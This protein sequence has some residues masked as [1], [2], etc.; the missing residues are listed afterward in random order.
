MNKE[1]PLEHLA[2]VIVRVWIAGRPAEEVVWIVVFLEVEQD[3]GRFKDVKI[4]PV[5]VDERGDAAVCWCA[6]SG[7]GIIISAG[8]RVWVKKEKAHD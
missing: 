5:G 8:A 3:R 1:H 6:F 7:G 2:P 4:V